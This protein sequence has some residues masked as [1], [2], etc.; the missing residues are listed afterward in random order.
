MEEI[1]QNSTQFKTFRESLS[2]GFEG[3]RESQKNA[4][5]LGSESAFQSTDHICFLNKFLFLILSIYWGVEL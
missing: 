3:E 4:R 2:F 5:D 1:T